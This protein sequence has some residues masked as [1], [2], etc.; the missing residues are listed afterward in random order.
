MAKRKTASQKLSAPEK[1][2]PAGRLS[3]TLLFWLAIFFLAF[4]VLA[5]MAYYQQVQDASQLIW[6]RN[7]QNG[8]YQVK[9]SPSPGLAT[10]TPKVTASPK[11][12]AK[13]KTTPTPRATPQTY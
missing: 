11:A 6:F 5:V 12:T 7:Q 1:K 4:S 10:P 8:I 13:P 3:D 9:P 2:R